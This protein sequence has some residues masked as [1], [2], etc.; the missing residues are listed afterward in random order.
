MSF[1]LEIFTESWELLQE[2]SIY[3]LFGIVVGG[4]LRVL[5]NPMTVAQHLGKG[6][7]TSVFKAALLGIPIPVCSC[8]VLPVAASLKKQ[9]ANNGAVTA[10]LISTP[11]SGVDSI[12]LTY[13]LLDP[14][15]TIAR[16]ATAFLSAAVAGLTENLFN[17][18]RD[19]K[20]SA[21]DLSCPVDNCCDGVDCPP[22]EHGR[23]HSLTE[24]L[25]FG[26]EYAFGELWGD[27]ALWFFI[28]LL[29][30][31]AITSLI[32]ADLMTMYL[33]GGLVAML[34]MLAAGIPLF[35]CATAS[36]PIAA[37]LIL[38]GVS[39]GAALVFLLTGP[40]TNIASL[41]VVVAILGRRAT[42]IYLTA[43]AGVAVTCGLAL[44]QIYSFFDLS[45]R[46]LAG[47]AAE[48]V[49]LWAQTTG[50]ILLLG[51]SVRPIYRS[52][53]VRVVSGERD[54][55]CEAAC[56]ALEASGPLV[57]T[58]QKDFDCEKPS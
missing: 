4:L 20:S 58:S 15:M 34:I 33:G 16:P 14:I 3:I 51:L 37:A 44:D 11:E 53:R 13:A 30:A 47:E 42:V 23:H 27:L 7:F 28:G 57:A 32:P 8:G 54:A 26:M 18:K 39:P 36:T 10:F 5:L 55:L 40:A 22:E 2:A 38:K 45:A 46:V 1:A 56:C 43:I 17:L 31:G 35:I 6:R 41:A 24:K 21:P 49:P 25:K 12:A 29:L 48:L 52:L 19:A 9:G 50:A